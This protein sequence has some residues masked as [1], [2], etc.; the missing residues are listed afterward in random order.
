MTDD[1]CDLR[2]LPGTKEVTETPVEKQFR[3]GLQT[4]D[5]GLKAKK[6]PKSKGDSALPMVPDSA[7]KAHK[8]RD[9]TKES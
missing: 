6:P 7:R 2:R 5:Q 1:K 3:R 8:N 4:D 9:S